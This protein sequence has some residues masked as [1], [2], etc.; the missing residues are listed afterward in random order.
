[1]NPLRVGVVGLGVISRF[2]LAALA[3]SP[4]WETVAVCD[5]DPG[6]IAD[7]P[8]G[9]VGHT[10]HRRMLA[11]ADLD[12]VVVTAPN[13]AHARICADAIAAG[14]AVCVEK[15][16]ALDLAEGEALAALARERGV[17]LFTAFHRR[18]N[19][20]FAALR[21]R[22][23]DRAVTEV[24]VRYEERI[25][26]HAG[27]DTWYLDPARCGGG[28]VADNGPNAFDLVETLL[29]RTEVA[30]ARVGYDEAGVDRRADIALTA[31]AGRA[32]VVLDW[33]HPGERK[34]VEVRTADGG[35]WTA[36]LLA[37]RPAFKESLWHEYEGVAADFA[38]RT[39][40]GPIE[41]GAG[42]SALRLVGDVYR[43]AVREERVGR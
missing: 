28:C 7:P 35:V 37:G 4:D 26:E 21:E 38:R 27:D 18:Y 9:A 31:G 20:G 5:L 25:E 43:A 8:P 13:D 2:H 15:P 34:D 32:R 39:R 11:E 10:D 30:G 40:R 33:S 14:A 1:M 22:I 17:P 12:A 41:D 3:A 29:G 42:V 19:S 24:T 23:G 16:L 6:R 36:D